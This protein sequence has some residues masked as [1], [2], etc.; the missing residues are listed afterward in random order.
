MPTNTY[1][2]KVCYTDCEPY[3]APPDYYDWN[4]EL[5][6]ID[7]L[8]NIKLLKLHTS[9]YYNDQKENPNDY[10]YNMYISS[11]PVSTTGNIWLRNIDCT[12]KAKLS[13]SASSSDGQHFFTEMDI[14]IIFRPSAPTTEIISR[15]CTDAIVKFH[16][17]GA[18]NYIIHYTT[19]PGA[20]Y[21][22]VVNVPNGIYSYT[23]SELSRSSDY[24]FIVEAIN[25]YG[26][27]TRG[28]QIKKNSCDD[29]Q[30]RQHHIKRTKNSSLQIKKGS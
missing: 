29:M 6:Y 11:L 5:Y 1:Y 14:K 16:S 12:I 27:K 18:V 2:F 22:H 24:Y 15:K 25:A 13:V 9:D 26:Q 7:Y 20:P 30:H 28:S 3:N 8:N 10:W 19:T 17:Q 4:L 23:F 21:E